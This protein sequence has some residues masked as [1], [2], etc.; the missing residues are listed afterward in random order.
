LGGEEKA[1]GSGQKAKVKRKI[2]ADVGAVLRD[3]VGW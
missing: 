1:K 2:T 3:G